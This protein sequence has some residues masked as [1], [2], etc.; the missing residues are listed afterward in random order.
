MENK[1]LCALVI[2][3]G[4]GIPTDIKRSAITKDNTKNLQEYAKIYPTTK[5]EASEGA[6]GLPDGQMG[7]SEVGHMTMGLGRVKDQSMVEINKAIKSGAFFENDA[8]LSGINKAK[9]RNSALHL[10]GIPT[11]GG[12]HSHINHLKALVEMSAKNGLKKVFVHFLG[13]GRDTPPRSALEYLESLQATFDELG[14]GKIASVIGR[15]YALD[16]DNNWDRVEKAYN[17]MIK[18]EGKYFKSPKEAINEAYKNGETD[19]FISP[20]VIINDNNE[21]IGKIETGDVVISYNYRTDRAKQL[22]RVFDSKFDMPWIEKGLKI[23]LITMTEYDENYDFA[24]VA[25]PP[26]KALN[27]L[28]EVLQ[29]RGLKQ[30]R[31]AETEKYAHVTFFFNDGK[32]EPFKGEDR[33]LVN[34]VKMKS[35]ATNPEMSAHIVADKTIDRIRSGDYNLVIVNFANPDMVGHSGD[36]EATKKAVSVVDTEVKRV[37]D[38]VLKAN[39]VAIVTADHGNADIMTLE[40]GEPCTSHTTAL[41][42]LFLIGKDCE[43]LKLKEGGSL[44]DIAPTILDIIGEEKPEEMIGESLIIKG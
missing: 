32:I 14:V 27:I 9:E 38:E 41:V 36:I 23:D 20:S 3:D 39:G 37:V 1:R 42:P 8:I 13:D 5:L 43:T 24:S 21:P 15:F 34:S 11:D 30:V 19:E 33:E 44:A 31:V 29:D 2:M 7:T 12:I 10:I 18:G 26:R 40:N 22:V 17:A 6:V 35:Y 25:F 4:F 28:G 16:R